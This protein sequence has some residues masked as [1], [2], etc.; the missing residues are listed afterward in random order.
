MAFSILERGE[1]FIQKR[2]KR[3]R[4]AAAFGCLAVVAAVGT[5]Y[6][7]KRNGTAVNY[8]YRE[9]ICTYE[10]HEHTEECY[11]AEGKLICGKAD[12][13][14]HVH[15]DDCYDKDGELVCTLPEI[16][17]HQ[18]EE[19]CFEEMPVLICE[20]EG[21]EENEIN[22]EIEA[23]GADNK[24]AVEEAQPPTTDNAAVFDGDVSGNDTAET[25]SNSEE[26]ADTEAADSAEAAEEAAPDDSRETAEASTENTA[27]SAEA[28]KPAPAEN[29]QETSDG[30][31]AAETTAANNEE[32][33]EAVA[34]D[35]SQLTNVSDEEI[36]ADAPTADEAEET[37][38][39]ISAEESAEP[40]KPAGTEETAAPGTPAEAG[41]AAEPEE[42]NAHVHTE[43][44]YELQQVA[45]CGQLELHK[46]TE[47]CCDETGAL[48]CGLLE[49]EEHVHDENCFEILEP[50]A[51]RRTF[52]GED[53]TITVSYGIEAGLPEEVEFSAEEIK[54]ETAAYEEYRKQA[55]N[56]LDKED[57]D[58]T[59]GRIFDIRFTL[60]DEEIEPKASVDVEISYQ[61]EEPKLLLDDPKVVHF[62]GE[63]EIPEVI[64]AEEREGI[65]TFSADG[66]SPMLV[67][68]NEV[69]FG[70]VNVQINDTIAEDGC[71]HAE[72]CG[73]E[74]N[75]S[76]T[77]E[78]DA[79]T[80][81]GYTVELTWF[82][83][84]SADT[85]FIQVERTL[86][87]GLNLYDAAENGEWLNVA[88]NQGA[89]C[90]YKVK[91]TIT[92]KSEE[93]ETFAPV[94]SEIYEI[95]Y[96]D[97]LRN[98]SF[99]APEAYN[100]T[101]GQKIGRAIQ[102]N[103]N[104]YP[105]LIWKSTAGNIELADI[106]PDGWKDADGSIK[107]TVIMPNY[108]WYGE[109]KDASGGK[110][111][112]EINCTS[113]GALYQT[114][115]T[116]PGTT[117]NW[118]FFHRARGT[119]AN[120]TPEYDEMYLVIMPEKIAV[121][122][123][124][125]DHENL[126]EFLGVETGDTAGIAAEELVTL[127]REN[128]TYKEKRGIQIVRAVSDDQNWHQCNGIYTVPEGQYLTRFFF[129][130]AR[131]S[132]G[133]NT[134]GN[135]IDKIWFSAS[136]PEPVPTPEGYARL[137]IKKYVDGMSEQELSMLKNKLHFEVTPKNT[138]SNTQVRKIQG[139]ELDWYS[140][141]S[142]WVGIWYEDVALEDIKK[143]YEGSGIDHQEF[144]YSYGSI[145]E[146]NFQMEDFACTTS[147]RKVET[148]R[149]SVDT[150]I[151]SQTDADNDI[152][153]G[154]LSENNKI[155]SVSLKYRIGEDNS[156]TVTDVEA[157]F[158]NSYLRT[159]GLQIKKIYT[160]AAGEK[161]GLPGAEFEIRVDG[162]VGNGTTDNEGV[163][164]PSGE[165]GLQ[166]GKRYTL[167]ETQAPEGYMQLK[168]SIYFEV[169]REEV[170]RGGG[171]LVT[172]YDKTGRLT[173]ETAEAETGEN[174]VIIEVENVPVIALPETGGSGTA[175]YIVIGITLIAAGLIYGG[176]QRMRGRR[177]G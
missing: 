126:K 65:Y 114:V 102:I 152:A 113:A 98:G 175:H 101:D 127:N 90:E 55:L 140:T 36:T 83:K 28:E 121:D 124:Y 106:R 64:D 141:G 16:E 29:S 51:G 149:T 81:A 89:E 35:D 119:N 59:S 134:A 112:A 17:A 77:V 53:Y 56:A 73:T 13:V 103:S 144:L 10:V 52:Y 86:I 131:T 30:D 122:G 123:A 125:A 167:T 32:A 116:T 75:E 173:G 115:L 44:C 165:V 71:L 174:P 154:E 157:E 153:G 176:M 84:S 92:G 49:L 47:E 87:E 6:A 67:A 60:N 151:E 79:L 9:L 168:E 24:T 145:E 26:T 40:E 38:P 128:D 22:E 99:E 142:H 88:L 70:A 58:I 120:D 4:F 18:H 160:N 78:I 61:N 171:Y 118:E 50:A 33:A 172:F 146:M 132:N 7:L 162:K 62:A 96:Y 2:K 107:D 11:D 117:L 163:Y 109:K 158:R 63:E 150:D 23:A 177:A 100:E 68:L 76:V 85:E 143:E 3:R 94:E 161:E 139:N 159:K 108:S 164:I 15:N 48:I 156:V 41:E 57:G 43:E 130:A 20:K 1:S 104:D 95:P 105:E 37:E 5:G 138:G 170:E 69:S 72:L 147:V 82:K 137:T 31:T 148:T 74:G 66:F 129:V 111:F 25:A 12:Y 34:A 136:L 19:S 46:H 135:F 169:T 54:P 166:I 21:I 133:D 91:L 8:E 110:Q 80:A 93:A 39:E 45:V 27:D 42:P 97:E 155:D 14:I